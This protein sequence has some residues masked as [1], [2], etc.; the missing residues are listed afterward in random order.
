MHSETAV[1]L[2]QLI[3]DMTFHQLLCWGNSDS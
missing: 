3:N 2:K 1:R